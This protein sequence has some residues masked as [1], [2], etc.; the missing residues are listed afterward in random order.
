MP[1]SHRGRKRGWEIDGPFRGRSPLWSSAADPTTVENPFRPAGAL[2]PL[3][4]TLPRA[5][6]AQGAEAREGN[7]RPLPRAKPALVGAADPTTVENPRAPANARSGGCGQAEPHLRMGAAPGA[8]LLEAACPATT[9]HGGLRPRDGQ[10]VPTTRQLPPVA[11]PEGLPSSVG[12]SGRRLA[13]QKQLPLRGT[14]PRAGLAQGRQRG[15]EIDAARPVG[16]ARSVACGGCGRAHRCFTHRCSAPAGRAAS[17][18]R[19]CAQHKKLRFFCPPVFVTHP[20]GCPAACGLHR[21]STRNHPP[22]IHATDLSAPCACWGSFCWRFASDSQPRLRKRR[23][24]H[25]TTWWCSGTASQTQ[26]TCR[27]A[28]RPWPWGIRLRARRT[29]RDDGPTVRFTSIT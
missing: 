22:R 14:L 17:A 21:C 19:A 28:P 3:R 13:L 26:A 1:A 2:V 8:R 15:R 11:N 29:S 12:R 9:R 20:A 24:R 25:G 5:G 16:E 4:G 18:N 7:R 10:L 6:L 23:R 27:H